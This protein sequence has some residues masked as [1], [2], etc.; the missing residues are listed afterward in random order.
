MSAVEVLE[1][2]GTDG[3]RGL[4]S[5]EVE[6]RQASHGPNQIDT[7]PPI[8]ALVRLLQQFANPVVYL[9]LA[10]IAISTAV[11]VIDGTEGIPFDVI[12]ISVIIVINAVVGFAHEARADQAVA[13]L[14]QLTG[15]EAVA[16]RDG[17]PGPVPAVDLVPGDVIL[18]SEGSVVP[19]DAR[20]LDV[21]GLQV[22]EATLTGESAPVVKTIDPVASGAQIGDR[23]NMVHSATAVVRGRGRAVVTATG[24]ETEVGRI[25]TLLHRTESEQTPLQREIDRVGVVL[26][27]AVVVIAT[28]VVGTLIALD[29][30]RSTSELLAALLIGVSLAVAAVPEGLPAVLSLVLALGV[31][32]M[33]GR[34]ALVKRLVAV[35]ALGSATIICSDKTGTLTRNEMLVR[36]IVVPA[37]E[38]DV[39]GSGY[40]S[41]GE[42]TIAGRPIDQ[43]T[44]RELSAGVRAILIAGGLASD[45]ELVEREGRIEAVGDPTEAAILAARPKAGLAPIDLAGGHDRLA[46]LPF[47]A[48]RKRMSVLVAEPTTEGTAAGDAAAGDDDD[49][50]AGEDQTGD[51]GRRR[52]RLVVKG[53][54]EELLGRCRAERAGDGVATAA[55]EPPGN[56]P[57]TPER[58][59]HWAEVVERLAG[60]GLRTLAVADRLMD[61]AGPWAGDGVDPVELDEECEQDLVLHGIIGI[62]DPPRA[63]AKAAIEAASTA[64]LRVAM[65]TGDHPRTAA[66]IATELGILT[67]GGE[68]VTGAQMEAIDDDELAALAAETT[69]Y[70]RVAP[71]H[72]LRIV[73]ALTA[74]GEVVAMTGDG[75]NDA[76]ALRAASIGIAMGRTG[77]DVSKEAADTILTDDNFATIVAAVHEGRAIYH[78]IRSFLRYLLSSNVGEVLT[79]FL[80][81]VLASTIGLDGV[82]GVVAPLLAVQILWINLVTDAAPA[83]ALGV[84]PAQPGLMERPPRGVDERVIDRPMQIGIVLIGATMAVATLAMLDLRL[85]G[86]LVDG[87]GD[88]TSARTSAFTVLVLAQLFNTFNARSDRESIGRGWAAN[89]WL[90]AAIALSFALQVAVV[91]LPFLNEAFGTEPMSLAEWGLAA[92]FA[93]SVLVVGEARKLVARRRP[94]PTGS[95]GPGPAV[96]SG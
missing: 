41:D 21:G 61:G 19:A 31:Q 22:S 66:A 95:F 28:V 44:D 93:A 67:S 71:E 43:E 34:N 80:G 7:E 73:N 2:L 25:A 11:W 74:Q 38:V 78:N 4:T 50:A 54:P 14:R 53:A 45:A 24:S 42:L 18:L 63:E 16:I 79:V 92:A 1:G 47:T 59:R 35:E 36:R 72:K 51:D 89:P 70:A 17:R 94:G 64:G 23:V 9:L 62:I 75:V 52:R 65:I 90:L 82:D 56:R 76:P 85:P 96:G 86:G 12:A 46:E 3:E 48:E 30:L 39:G 77:T 8:P 69:V 91:H 37:G 6:R 27:T 5:A 60:E 55:G 13:A 10:A 49:D 57:L 83:L 58:R 15:P 84:D 33:A 26:G 87:T 40:G 20:L 68:V 81:V 32:R 88:E 29:G